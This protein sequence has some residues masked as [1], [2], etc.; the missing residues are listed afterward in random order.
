VRK[1][2]KAVIAI[3]LILLSSAAGL[4]FVGMAKANWIFPPTEPMVRKS[5][6]VTVDSPANGTLYREGFVLDFFLSSPQWARGPGKPIGS[7]LGLAYKIDD[8]QEQSIPVPDPYGARPDEYRRIVPIPLSVLSDGTHTLKIISYCETYY[9]PANSTSYEIKTFKF[10]A[11]CAVIN[12]SVAVNPQIKLVTPENVTYCTSGVA[13]NLTID[14]PTSWIEYSFD[15][16][17][18]VTIAGNTTLTNLEDGLHNLVVYAN[19]TAGNV[20][21]S[22]IV[23]FTVDAHLSLSPTITPRE[24]ESSPTELPTTEPTQTWT[25]FVDGP[26]LLSLLIVIVIILAIGTLGAIIYFR[27]ARQRIN[28]RFLQGEEGVD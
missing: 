22:E 18:N 4:Q 12:F 1:P 24:S 8:Q 21:K 10:S 3:W 23:Y 26:N 25:D 14:R 13:V 6:I 5:P 7:I 27:G 16:Q 20:G 11:I 19:D 2:F 17:N 28:G 9:V 15:N